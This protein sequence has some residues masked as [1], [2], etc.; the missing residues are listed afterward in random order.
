[1]GALRAYS[2]A[3]MDNEYQTE[4]VPDAA[5]ISWLRIAFMNAIFSISLP[6]FLG[7]LELSAAT[8]AWTFV[9]GV[10]AGGLVLTVMAAFMGVIGTQTR[11]S[12]YMLA[13]FAF[14]KQASQ[15]LNLAFGLSLLGWFGVNIELF[16]D[17]MVLLSDFMGLEVPVIAL[18]ILGGV[19]MTAL[20]YLGLRRINFLSLIVTP[21]LA[22]VTVMMLLL[23]LD[24]G[25]FS[26]LLAKGPSEGLSFGE[27]LSATVGAVAVGAVIM[28]D[29]CR[30]VKG[31]AGGVGVAIVTY[32]IS[33]P[34][35]TLVAGLAGLASGQGD[36]LPLML[37]LGLGFG[38]FAI[39]FGGSTTLNA[40]NLYSATLSAGTIWP[41]M[42]R[43][44]MVLIGGVGGTIF[45]FFNILD[46][47]IP[48][49]LYLTV[50]FIPVGAV[51]VADYFLVPSSTYEF[52]SFDEVDSIRWP[53]LIS[54]GLGSAVAFAGMNGLL[55]LT[56]TVAFDAILVTLCAH[57]VL[58]RFE[59]PKAIEA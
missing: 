42:S 7:G 39:V 45:A 53:A 3:C 6:T 24:A 19:M 22:V 35:V 18:E 32:F 10:I 20:T 48:F 51:I 36:I 9:W 1:L 26:Q 34:A 47:F 12:S 56:G 29:T 52:I 43:N 49:L 30:F 15:L 41:N 17:S 14:G 55:T 40:L 38:A 8:P 23:V 21:V 5:S 16:A 25:S 28:P 33:A 2:G 58:S 44:K 50:I 11:L 13:R 4:P 46:S 31:W 37:A 54:W 27:V 57:L 59:T